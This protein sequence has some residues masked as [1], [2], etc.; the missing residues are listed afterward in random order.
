MEM[1][2][3]DMRQREY[4]ILHTPDPAAWTLQPGVSLSPLLHRTL[5]I[6]KCH[7]KE[8]NNTNNDD[9]KDNMNYNDNNSHNCTYY[10]LL[11]WSKSLIFSKANRVTSGFL[12]TLA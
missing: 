12:S 4:Q 5:E 3:I 8:T 2:T 9:K 1:W 10:H 11:S 6:Y 7:N